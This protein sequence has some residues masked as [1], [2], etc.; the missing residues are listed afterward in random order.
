MTTNQDE[1]KVTE[2][3]TDVRPSYATIVADPPWRYTVNHPGSAGKRVRAAEDHYETM[4]QEEIAALPVA[5]LAA[6]NAHLYLW[7]T[8]PVL[9]EQR[10]KGG[11]NVFAIVRAWGFE[12]KTLLT[13]VKS[14]NGSGLGWYFRGDTEHVIFAV[15]GTAPI[16]ASKRVSNVFRHPRGRHSRKPG[17]FF[18]LVE[19]V[20]PGPYLELFARETRPGWHVWGNEVESDVEIAA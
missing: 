2:S 10:L 4:T 14:E 20:S 1:T 9:T 16:E 13:W 18:E 3:L 17:T 6:D 11:P 15:R 19:S 5:D 8:N 12:P 7:V